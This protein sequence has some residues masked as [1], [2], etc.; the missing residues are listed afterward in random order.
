MVMSTPLPP[1]K[2]TVQG[3]IMRGYTHPYSSHLLF[4]FSSKAAASQFIKA[5]LPY[6]RSAENWGTNKPDKMLNIGLTFTGISIA[7]SLTKTELNAFPNTFTT[8]PASQGSQG[9]L[10]DYGEGDPE[11]WLFGGLLANGNPDPA[12]RVDAI[13]HSYAM[14][15]NSLNELTDFIAKAATAAGVVELLPLDGGKGRL[16]QYQLP[17]DTIHFGYRDGISEPD[18]NWPETW[19][20]P[21]VNTD[22][23]D[24]NN[25]LI[26]YPNSAFQP[27]PSN[28][29]TPNA[30]AFAKDGCYN[31]FRVLYQD[32]N[33]FDKY[34]SDN[35]PVVAQTLGKSTEYVKEWLAAK[36]NGR[37]R[38]GSPLILSPDA[39]DPATADATNF[40]YTE[41][42]K[43]LKCPFSAHTRVGNPRDEALFPAESP[44]PRL[45]R[46]GVPYGA[47]PVSDNDKGE[48]GL[49]GLFLCGALASQFE[50]IY[51]WINTNNFSPLFS[52]NFDTQ[53]ALLANRATPDIDTTFTIPI[54]G[55]AK[56][57]VLPKLPQFI[58]ARGTAYC[59]LPSIPTLKAIAEG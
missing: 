8:G 12:K 31:A 10:Q 7:S 6:L 9:S 4:R 58:V 42:T 16:E 15:Q 49:I 43:G 14:H 40:S 50:L 55:A 57:L 53:D 23:A 1:D 54:P 41:D 11:K 25:F 13:V 56:P 36:L 52:P 26:G 32:V 17:V 59:L 18:L 45:I 51:S 27:G 37:W 35:A 3:L 20:A 29:A 19:P 21:P 33:A 48:R 22:P 30:S 2:S 38:N 46:R 44:V 24:L 28:P 47:P 5:L 34:L 39:P